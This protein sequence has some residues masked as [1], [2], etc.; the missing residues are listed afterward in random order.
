MNSKSYFRVDSSTKSNNSS[1]SKFFKPLIASSLSLVLTSI[2]M[3]QT[4]ES[5][6]NKSPKTTITTNESGMKDTHLNW[7]MACDRNGNNCN[8]ATRKV[9]W[10]STSNGN[11]QTWTATTQSTTGSGND[12]KVVD[13][14]E[15]FFG[16]N[17]N[18]ASQIWVLD[19]K[20]NVSLNNNNK[21][22]YVSV[23]G[24]KDA[25][26]IAMDFEN[27]S[28]GRSDDKINLFI[29]FANTANKTAEVTNLK[30]LYGNLY[31]TTGGDGGSGSGIPMGNKYKVEV[32]S[33]YGDIYTRARKE[34]L[35][36]WVFIKNKLEGNITTD[37]YS[38]TTMNQLST[39]TVQVIFDD[40]ASMR[41]NIGDYVK[42]D[43]AI[44]RE[45]IFKGSGKD[46]YV[47]K[48]NI[49][50]YSSSNGEGDPKK[51]EDEGIRY[52]DQG[53]N[54]VWFYKG[55][56]DGSII[57][58]GNVVGSNATNTVKRG[59]NVVYFG[60][61]GESKPS[62]ISV[63]SSKS[64][65]INGA[66][67]ANGDTY[68]TSFNLTGGILA[69]LF[70]TSNNNDSGKVG[71]KGNDENRDGVVATNSIHVGK[72]A[73]LNLTG[74]GIDTSIRDRG[75]NGN[76]NKFMSNNPSKGLDSGLRG[77]GQF[78]V[79]KDS[80]V[81]RGYASNNVYLSD[82]A[83]INLGSNGEGMMYTTIDNLNMG[84]APKTVSNLYINGKNATFNGNIVSDGNNDGNIVINGNNNSLSK[85]QW[86]GKGSQ[87]TATNNIIV[88]KGGSGSILGNITSI[89]GGINNISFE[90]TPANGMA[91]NG[92]SGGSGN[93]TSTL[94][95]KGST[96]QINTLMASAG[97][98]STLILDSSS[99]KQNVSINNISGSTTNGMSSN[100]NI[101]FKGDKGSILSLGNNS[102]LSSR[103]TAYNINALTSSGANNTINLSGQAYGSNHTPSRNHF[104]TL[105]M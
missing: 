37:D 16:N 46:G 93:D 3:G 47:L 43:D 104:Q 70:S 76:N 90:N 28:L 19:S 33:I 53:S 82:D 79:F 100:L 18:T 101:D 50:S 26:K 21:D 52:S 97:T 5:M 60:D 10:S 87:G 105:T 40:G 41:G 91:A 54:F 29:N 92:K 24:S 7:D 99:N 75:N 59:N 22:N 9:V 13:R 15:L 65:S 4:F 25:S 20:E 8:G 85:D 67:G 69:Q 57:A 72:G 77:E 103:S 49:I 30:D 44:K 32:D 83:R 45:V 62:D 39:P 73:T 55:N 38:N 81:A 64:S 48:G 102:S 36:G 35:S 14:V 68:G 74:S 66:N 27:T 17:S 58:S 31:L 80:I 42:R 1:S 12:S 6:A 11:G 78:T 63:D 86:V 89:G 71:V 95:L 96:N 2:A 88:R 98:T 56:M 61:P 51:P 84:R 23:I 94:T 34:S